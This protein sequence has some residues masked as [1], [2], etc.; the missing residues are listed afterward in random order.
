MARPVL[1]TG[2]VTHHVVELPKQA[3]YDPLLQELLRGET[4][5]YGGDESR[6]DYVLLMK[7]LHW[8]GDNVELTK[9]IF[10]ASPLGQREKD[11]QCKATSRRGSVSYVD[12]TIQ[13]ILRTRTN[14]PPS[15]P[16][17]ELGG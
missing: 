5:R 16:S 12:M 2:E 14:L 4:T 7:L 1:R 11:G 15:S 3:A 10:L 9:S 17:H 6:A 13:K 8:T